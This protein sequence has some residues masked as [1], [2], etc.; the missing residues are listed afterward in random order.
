MTRAEL[1]AVLHDFRAMVRARGP[2]E[3]LQVATMLTCYTVS[4]P[5]P[6][7]NWLFASAARHAL[8][9]WR[10]DQRERHGGPTD[11]QATLHPHL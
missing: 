10:W 11:G 4:D 1:R 6:E 2:E 7:A 9:W 8:R 5:Q 3:L